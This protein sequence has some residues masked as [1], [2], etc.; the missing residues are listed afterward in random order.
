MLAGFATPQGT[1]RFTAR[2]ASAQHARFYRDVQGLTASSIGIGSYL[3][4]MDPGIDRGYTEAT[5]AAVRGGINFLDTS[6]NY[7]NQRSERSI[8]KG[9]HHL[10]EGGELRRDEFVICTKAGYLVPDAV[11]AGVLRENDVAGGM[12]SMAPGFLA[13]QLERSR[14]NLDLETLDVFYLHNP[15]TQLQFLRHEE[16]HGRIREAFDF[17][18]TAVS[19]G[20][21]RYYGTATWDGYR[22]PGLLLLPRLAGIAREVGG[23]GHHFRFIQLPFNLAMPEAFT[24]NVEGKRVV[25]WAEELGISVVASA[26]L[27]QARLSRGLPDVLAQWAPDTTTDAQRA[28]QFARSAPG[29]AVALV[30]MSRTEHVAENLAV[31]AIPPAT[32]A[33]FTRLFA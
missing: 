10:L 5:I 4:D 31:A 20:R 17:L 30:G 19:D 23:D 22:K 26:S 3:G 21:I 8:A 28:I 33:E 1:V 7:R 16:F 2:F 25:E 12:H 27:A 11:P 32:P 9:L 6:L 29:V 15:E 13:D 18:E 24:L 14:A